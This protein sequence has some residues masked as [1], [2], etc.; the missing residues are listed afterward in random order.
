[1]IA[2]KREIQAAI[3]ECNRSASQLMQIF[4]KIQSHERT[5]LMLVVEM[6]HRALLA[7]RGKGR[8]DVRNLTNA[9]IQRGAALLYQGER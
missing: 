5:E 9:A 2:E 3:R 8:E 7:H 6:M 1:M 4:A